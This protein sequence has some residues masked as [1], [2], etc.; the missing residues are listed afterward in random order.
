MCSSSE[1]FSDIVSFLRIIILVDVIS[2]ITATA[3]GSMKPVMFRMHSPHTF[4]DKV[5]TG[6]IEEVGFL[7]KLIKYCARS[8]FDI[9]PSNY[10]YAIFWKSGGEP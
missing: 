6:Q 3:S 5:H 7:M 8:V 4:I 2:L 10:G 1:L 9:C